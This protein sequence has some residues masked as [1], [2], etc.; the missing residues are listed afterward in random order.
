MADDF[1]WHGA[2]SAI[3]AVRRVCQRIVWNAGR[4]C[5]AHTLTAA[6]PHAPT[7]LILLPSQTGACKGVIAGDVSGNLLTSFPLGDDGNYKYWAF[8]EPYKATVRAVAWGARVRACPRGVHS[9]LTPTPRAPLQVTKNDGT[10][11]DEDIYEAYNLSLLLSGQ[12][13]AIAEG[14]GVRLNGEKFMHLKVLTGETYNAKVKD[15]DGTEASYPVTIDQIH[16]LK[17]GSTGLMIGEKGGYFFAVY[18]DNSNAK[19]QGPDAIAAMAI[20]FYCA[21]AWARVRCARRGG[22]RTDRARAFPIPP[23]LPNRRGHW[24]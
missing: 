6:R 3:V 21:A 24:A 17:K 9:P 11:A 19:Q 22:A 10:E 12:K 18:A 14:H 20:G 4:R 8:A 16:V 13:G 1:D 15:A 2:C 23:I 5:R 7:S